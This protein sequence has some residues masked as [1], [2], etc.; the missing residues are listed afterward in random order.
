[1]RQESVDAPVQPKMFAAFQQILPSSLAPFDPILVLRT[2]SD[3]LALVDAVR[4]VVRT[5]APTLAL[6]SVMSMDDRVSASLVR[7]RAYALLL[8]G[9]ASAAALIAGVGLF[10]VLSYSVAQ[11][12]REL[13]VRA[14][15]PG[16]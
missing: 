2:E 11:R 12:A 6:E 14:G 10:G 4:S 5:H 9:L 16:H 15:E 3:P 1:M 7:P 13:G 8:G